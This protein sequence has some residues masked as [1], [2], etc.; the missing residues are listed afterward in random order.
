VT[1]GWKLATSQTDGYDSRE[2]L[3]AFLSK[4]D[5]LVTEQSII[6][7]I[8]VLYAQKG[9]CR[10]LVIEVSPEGWSQNIFQEASK[11]MD[12][13]FYVFRGSVYSEQPTV[14]TATLDWWSSYLRRLGLSRREAPPIGV[15]AAT[16]CADELPWAN[17]ERL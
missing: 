1:F 3:I 10:L 14:L 16:D 11:S 13:R 12:H 2:T 6:E 8:P 15:A 4:S 5:F 17:L 7:G 9:T